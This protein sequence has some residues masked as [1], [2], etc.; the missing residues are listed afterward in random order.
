MA[1]DTERVGQRERHPV[2][3]VVRGA[4]GEAVRGLGVGLVP[5]VALEVQDLR[6]GHE[7]VVDVGRAELS[8]RAEVRVHGA[9]GVGGDDDEAATAR[10]AARRGLGPEVDTGGADVVAEDGTELVVGD[11]A[12]VRAAATE[13]RDPDQRVGG[14]A[15]GDLDC[16]THRRVQ[17]LG[18]LGV[19]E[20][21]RARCELLLGDELVG[22]V[23]EHVDERVADADD[24]E[25]GAHDDVLL[26]TP[27]SVTATDDAI[28]SASTASG[29]GRSRRPSVWVRP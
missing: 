6:G 14:R 7:L 22:L 5:Q 3:G 11:T 19:D 9:L 20:G 27:P 2:A 10:L 23:A 13:R 4:G 29:G 26:R 24:V 18:P 17:R 12:D 25:A 16:G 8:G 28:R 21:H 15:T 1:V